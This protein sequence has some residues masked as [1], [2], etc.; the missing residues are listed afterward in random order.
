LDIP[1]VQ[2]NYFMDFL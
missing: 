1:R 2:H